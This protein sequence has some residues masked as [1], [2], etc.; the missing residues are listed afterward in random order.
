MRLNQRKQTR[1][2]SNLVHRVQ[3]LLPLALPAILLETRLSRQ[4]P[5]K[6]RLPLHASILCKLAVGRELVQSLLSGFCGRFNPCCI[7]DN[8]GRNC[9]KGGTT[10]WSFLEI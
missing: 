5:L 7:A 8:V 10:C 4:R 6:M 3:K 2:G 1:P 9:E